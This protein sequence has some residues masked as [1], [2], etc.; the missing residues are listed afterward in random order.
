MANGFVARLPYYV[1]QHAPSLRGLYGYTTKIVDSGG[2]FYESLSPENMAGVVIISPGF[3]PNPKGKAAPEFMYGLAKLGIGSV[4]VQFG[5]ENSFYGML[6]GLQQVVNDVS[7]NTSVPLGLKGISVC[8]ALV[9][10][11]ASK[12]VRISALELD[13]MFANVETAQQR[14]KNVLESDQNPFPYGIDKCHP[15]HDYFFG[16]KI[17]NL[18]EAVR[19]VKQRDIPVLVQN[20]SKDVLVREAELRSLLGPFSLNGSHDQ[21]GKSSE[22]TFTD[23]EIGNLRLRIY[24]EGIHFIHF[25]DT[26]NPVLEKSVDFFNAVFRTPHPALPVSSELSSPQ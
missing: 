11:L 25:G 21:N 4:L 8:S 3:R 9:L 13:S 15:C 19:A 20:G 5:L 22:D 26:Y 1:N 6:D 12:D 17:P 10:M 2:I 23:Y 24:R 16:D 18:E 7:T 14:L